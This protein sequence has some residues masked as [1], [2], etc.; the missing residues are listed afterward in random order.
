MIL[1]LT[2]PLI[3][4]L[5]LLCMVACLLLSAKSSYAEVTLSIKVSDN[6]LQEYKLS[7]LQKSL[8]SYKVNFYN[9]HMGKDKNYEGFLIS[10]LFDF[11]YKDKW[12][13]KDYSD[14][15]FIA[16]DGYEAVSSLDKFQETG[17]YLTFKDL[18]MNDG[19]ELIG[20][21][22]ADPGPFFLIWIRDHQ[23]TENAY[24]WPWQV[25]SINLLSFVEQ[26]PN[27]VPQ[28]AVISS[29]EY[30]GFEIFRYRCLRCHAIS[31]QGGKIGPDLNAPQNITSYRS[32]HMIKEMI[33]H[34]SKY[35]H[36]HMPD[37]TDLSEED[38][39]NIYNYLLYQK[40]EH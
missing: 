7:E 6:T 32:K 20:R 33:R 23:T 16:L 35:R 3:R 30:K 25:S 12:K 1:R 37:H 17:G 14:I 39:D 19:W 28:G 31:Q 27:V 2:S 22:Q 9:P 34:P 38:L 10:E 13:S 29:T 4:H 8:P 15:A 24:P 21:K 11:I 40:A 18:D 26:Y 36:T 5:L